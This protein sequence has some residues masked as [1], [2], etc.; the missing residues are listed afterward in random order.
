MDTHP[1]IDDHSSFSS[2]NRKERLSP[3]SPSTLI[4]SQDGD[5]ERLRLELIDE[6]E[7]EIDE[8]NAQLK[9]IAKLLTIVNPENVPYLRNKEAHFHSKK[10]QL[11]CEKQFLIDQKN[12]SEIS[13][14]PSTTRLLNLLCQ[15]VTSILVTSTI[16]LIFLFFLI[17]LPDFPSLSPLSWL[18]YRF[19]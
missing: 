1:I 8:L 4:P 11:H 3:L 7:Q 10:S 15:P 9:E 19:H 17:P 14:A 13:L 16:S 6:V 12:A 18:T 2:S 5:L